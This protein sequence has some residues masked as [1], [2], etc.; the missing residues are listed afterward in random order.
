MPTAKP[1][2]IPAKAKKV[3]DSA[4]ILCLPVATHLKDIIAESESWTVSSYSRVVD[5]LD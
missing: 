4:F 2:N 1:A 5:S 3:A